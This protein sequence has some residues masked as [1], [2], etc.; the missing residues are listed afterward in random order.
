[1]WLTRIDA[2]DAAIDKIKSAAGAA[3]D[4]LKKD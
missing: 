2:V 4:E 3:V 1:L